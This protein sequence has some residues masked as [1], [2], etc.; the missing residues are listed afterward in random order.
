MARCC[1]QYFINNE[2]D[3]CFERQF[4]NHRGGKNAQYQL[5][6]VYPMTYL[7][8]SPDLAMLVFS[9]KGSHF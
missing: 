6:T 3:M 4:L 7:C 5:S 8:F 1:F 9:V 2:S